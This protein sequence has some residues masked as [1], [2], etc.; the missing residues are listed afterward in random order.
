MRRLVV[1]LVALVVLALAA[2]AVAAPP[3]VRT[4]TDPTE[5]GKAYD[6]VSV[7]LEAAPAAGRKA[8]VTVV[9][10]RRV[11]VGD[12]ID[13]WVDTDDDRVPDLFITGLSFSEYGVYKARDWD[14][15]HPDITDRG[16]ATVKMT[17]R[18]SIIRFDPGCLGASERFAVSV[19]SHGQNRAA[20]T[21]DYVPRPHR[22]TKRVLSYEA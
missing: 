9:H 11:D 21:D 17:G 12:G 14:R 15:H 19:R 16:C 3:T 10:G 2:P 22:W 1:P 5:P 8:R 20:R 4:I 6:I 7:T 13:V 18:K